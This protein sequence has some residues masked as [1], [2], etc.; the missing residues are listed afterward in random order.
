MRKWLSVNFWKKLS[1]KS[2][3]SYFLSSVSHT[4]AQKQFLSFILAIEIV[5]TQLL[6]LIEICWVNFCLLLY[7]QSV[8]FGLIKVNKGR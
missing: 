7:N 3:F 5:E 6:F 4:P 1:M 8:A 2:M